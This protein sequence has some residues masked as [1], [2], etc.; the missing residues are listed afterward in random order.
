MPQLPTL[1]IFGV[2]RSGTTWLGQL[3][4]SAPT[5]AYRY[6][7]LFSYEFKDFLKPG[8]SSKDIND[9][10]R[11]LLHAESDFVL[12]PH[13]FE[14]TESCHLVWKSVRYHNLSTEILKHS[15]TKIIYISRDPVEVLNSWYNAPR[16]FLPHWDIQA[17]W[18]TAPSKNLGRAEEFYGY[19]GW[20]RAEA[21]HRQNA[22]D[23]PNQVRIVDYS[24]LKSDTERTL[25]DLFDWAQIPF[26]NPTLEFI[27]ATSERSKSDTYSVFKKPTELSLPKNIVNEI[28]NRT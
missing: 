14:K 9:F 11:R 4:N 26:L 27:A 23:F 28:A 10:H 15:Q 17:E 20:Q 6:Q 18:R 1:A 24:T 8:M 13:A 5:V 19:E 25:R 16:E 3:F 2:P 22:I 7:P 12:P 21:I